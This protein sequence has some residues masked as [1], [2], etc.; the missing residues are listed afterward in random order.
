MANLIDSAVSRPM[1]GYSS[2]FDGFFSQPHADALAVPP[3][4]Q[5]SLF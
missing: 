1:I 5:K 3:L 4:K 2:Q